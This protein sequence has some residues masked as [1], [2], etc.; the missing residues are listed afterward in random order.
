MCIAHEI[1]VQ[2][3]TN[4]RDFRKYMTGA[5]KY[6]HVM[7]SHGHKGLNFMKIFLV[8][9]KALPTSSD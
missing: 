8:A 5:T 4:M 3:S 2:V 1:L 6:M 7:R 9:L